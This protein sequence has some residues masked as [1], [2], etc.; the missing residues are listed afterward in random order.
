MSIAISRGTKG[1][2]SNSFNQG[3]ALGALSI[4][5]GM[6]N[7]G[8]AV[9]PALGDNVKTI[10][11]FD[12][13]LGILSLKQML[14]AQPYIEVTVTPTFPSDYR[15][16]F[17]VIRGRAEYKRSFEHSP[18]KIL[19]E[20]N[21]LEPPEASIVIN[22][23]DIELG[24][25]YYYSILVLIGS[26]QEGAHYE[27][28]ESTGFGTAY[29]YRLFES[30][31]HMFQLLPEEWQVK[32]SD[33]DFT[34]RFIRIFG[35]LVDSIRTDIEAYVLKANSIWDIQEQQL[36]LLASI[37]GWEI[38]KELR[39]SVQRQEL[40][41]ASDF[42]K[43]KGRDQGVKFLIQLV[44]GWEVEFE[45]GWHRVLQSNGVFGAPD[46]TDA[47][48]ISHKSHPWVPVV[49][50]V[51]G[52]STGLASQVFV[53]SNPNP[54]R[55]VVSVLES[56]LW[57]NWLE[58]LPAELNVGG[59]PT[60]KKFAV[61]KNAFGQGF[62]TFPDGVN[63]K[64]PDA[65]VDNVQSSYV[66][67]GDVLYYAPEYPTSNEW[68]H[69]TGVRLLISNTPSSHPITDVI[70]NKIAKIL[71]QKASYVVYAPLVI[72][73]SSLILEGAIVA[74]DSYVD[75]QTLGTILRSN[76]LGHTSNTLNY[77]SAL[78]PA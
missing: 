33:S 24:E 20:N 17:V 8:Y 13:T 76:T 14:G 73:D 65:G 31:S 71:E 32:Q 1:L 10:A 36:P 37:V 78:H 49:D 57:S 27:Y 59:D 62:V 35:Y 48:A 47:Y 11:N 63:G 44:S 69:F 12:D 50:E 43:I 46:C 38:N 40:D 42:Y 72:P 9:S 21:A 19:Y 2:K 70:L 75:T 67:G 53:L 15:R 4:A 54:D 29:G 3:A 18:Y 66:H 34:E 5:T 74:S 26:E 56:G 77:I 39:E 28:N 61:S 68:Y 52:S 7:F 58:V 16:H 55:I 23:Y 25:H 41:A 22:D 64:V 60:V 30:D 6:P 51:V 45:Q